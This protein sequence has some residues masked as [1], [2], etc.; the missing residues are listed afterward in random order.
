M[1]EDRFVERYG[2]PDI[3][4]LAPVLSGAGG[5]VSRASGAVPGPVA[6][7]EQAVDTE[8]TSVVF[9]HDGPLDLPHDPVSSTHVPH[10]RRDE[11]PAVLWTSLPIL[12]VNLDLSYVGLEIV[13]VLKTDI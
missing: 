4:P 6:G 3:P 9:L 12:S 2:S 1:R 13:A 10:Q 8:T 7:V 11:L 5:G